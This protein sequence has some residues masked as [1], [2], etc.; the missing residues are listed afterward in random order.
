MINKQTDK[1]VKI[2]VKQNKKI[3][4]L[5]RLTPPLSSNG[6]IMLMSISEKK[7]L[8]KSSY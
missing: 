2:S 4:L 7:K 8:K 5:L 1:L 3:L 6:K